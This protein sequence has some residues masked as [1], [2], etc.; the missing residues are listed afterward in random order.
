MKKAKQLMQQSAVFSTKICIL[1]NL[2]LLHV[3]L[4]MLYI[5]IYKSFTESVFISYNNVHTY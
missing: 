4:K 2:S 5:Y 3:V 1:C